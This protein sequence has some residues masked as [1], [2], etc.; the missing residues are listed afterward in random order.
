M[1][2]KG[3]I[4]SFSTGINNEPDDPEIDGPSSGTLE[5][6]YTYTFYS[7]DLDGDNVSY[8]IEWGDGNITSWTAYQPSGQPGYIESHSWSEQG[9]Y[10]IRAKAKDIWGYESGWTTFEVAIPKNKPFNFNSFLLRF[11]NQHPNLFPV[12]RN[13]LGY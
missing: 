9:T 8:Y 11:L 7:E 3:D 12:L 10:V 5:K 4:W 2:A 1:K 6:N 13:L